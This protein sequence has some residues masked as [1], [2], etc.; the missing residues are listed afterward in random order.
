MKSN[1]LFLAFAWIASLSLTTSL[2]IIYPTHSLRRRTTDLNVS[3]FYNFFFIY[4]GVE[5]INLW[6]CFRMNTGLTLSVPFMIIVWLKSEVSSYKVS[7][8]LFRLRAQKV[9]LLLQFR[10]TPLTII[11]P[12]FFVKSKCQYLWITWSKF[13]H[14]SSG[15]EYHAN[16]C[17]FQTLAFV[18]L[19]YTKK[20]FFFLHS[21]LFI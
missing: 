7:V 15:L 13:L 17:F 1:A 6:N 10:S 3:F 8:R 4:Y 16:V 20:V 14:I 18:F 11:K 12:F 19:I 2:V 9:L 21:K 5:V